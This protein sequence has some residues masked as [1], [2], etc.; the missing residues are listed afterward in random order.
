[1]TNK[2]EKTVKAIVFEKYGSP[3][4]MHLKEVSP[5]APK[6]N[7]VLIK[8]HAVSINAADSHLLRADPFLVRFASGLFKPKIQTLGADVAGRVEAVGG[9]VTQFKAGDEVFGDLSGAGFGGLAEYVCA[10][11]NILALKPSN[12]GFEEAAA[13]PMAAVTAL[14]GLRDVGKIQA[15]QKVMIYGASGG[16]GA[17]AVQI[18]K[19]H[20]AEVTAVCSTSKMDLARSLGAHHVMDYTREDFTQSGQRYDLIFAANGN[21]ALS[22][23]EPALTSTG[24]FVLSG[25]SILRIFQAMLLGPF[26]SKKGGKTFQGFTAKPSQADLNVVKGLIESGKVKPVIDRRYPLSETPD[27]MRYLEEGHARGKIVIIVA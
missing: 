5:P 6:D 16:V 21:R 18:A 13:V 23:F 24:T 1:V 4:V 8:V 2:G 22:D 10:P 26:K 25:G 27:A 19:A 9:S 15:G 3:D 11:E 14:Q 20:G 7:E 12:L 17:F